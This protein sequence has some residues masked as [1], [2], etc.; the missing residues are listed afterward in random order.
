MERKLS[1]MDVDSAAGTLHQLINF[2]INNTNCVTR[3]ESDYQDTS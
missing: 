2:K 3:L 1:E